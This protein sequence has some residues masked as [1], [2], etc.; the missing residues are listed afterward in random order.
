MT[1]EHRISLV[2]PIPGEEGIV[3]EN[4]AGSITKVLLLVGLYLNE[5][6][7]EIVVVEELVVVVAQ[8]Q[9]L[10]PLQILQDVDCGLRVVCGDVPQN[11]HMVVLLHDGVPVV[12]YSVVVVLRPIQFIMGKS[13]VV[14]S[15]TDWVGVCLISEMYIRYIEKIRQESNLL[16][17]RLFTSFLEFFCKYT[18]V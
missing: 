15:P 12:G 16:S 7:S 3:R 4:Q 14:L 6:V 2:P 9:M 8:N 11:E 5:L 13:K 17:S 18:L 1:I 10:L